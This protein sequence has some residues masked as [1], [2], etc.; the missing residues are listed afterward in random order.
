MGS[1][2]A[3]AGMAK[4]PKSDSPGV[5]RGRVDRCRARRP[6]VVVHSPA[7]LDS[8]HRAQSAGGSSRSGLERPQAEK[9]AAAPRRLRGDPT[10]SGSGDQSRRTA[11]SG[12]PRRCHRCSGR[13]LLPRISR[14][15]CDLRPGRHRPS[16]G[17]SP[18]RGVAGQHTLE[19]PDHHIV[20]P[21]Q[22]GSVSAADQG[23]VADERVV[24]NVAEAGVVGQAGSV[25]RG[26]GPVG[27]TAVGRAAERNGSGGDQGGCDQ[28]A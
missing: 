7:G 12:R 28:K 13:R 14:H 20:T 18:Y 2:R 26:A 21:P 25:D 3:P 27:T 5:R 9:L 23:K 24:A 16:F 8:R 4:G 10:D 1:S 11:G 15:L 6:A 22:N 17:C 19:G